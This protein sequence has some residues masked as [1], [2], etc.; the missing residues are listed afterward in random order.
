[1]G[2]L[3]LGAVRNFDSTTRK[4]DVE[5]LGG[6]ADYLKGVALAGHVA[7]ATVT[8]GVRVVVAVFGPGAKDCVVMGVWA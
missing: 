4:V 3:M 5:L 1:M 8:D 7:S 6:D 2:D